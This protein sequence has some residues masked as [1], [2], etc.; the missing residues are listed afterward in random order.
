MP[1]GLI[2]SEF[3]PPPEYP[4]AHLD[5]KHSYPSHE[6]LR[7]LLNKIGLTY[8]VNT[9]IPDTCNQPQ[10]IKPD[11]PLSA[12]EM[13][14]TMIATVVGGYLIYKIFKE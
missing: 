10:I 7:S 3:E 13:A 4:G 8:K 12:W 9:P 14:F 5:P 6:S 2:E 11:R 1:D